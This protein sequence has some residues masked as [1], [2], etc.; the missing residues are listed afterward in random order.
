M[1]KVQMSINRELHLELEDAS[2]KSAKHAELLQKVED[3][4]ALNV[5]R[6]SAYMRWRLS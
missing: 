5:K 3:Y 2:Q 6:C 4:E 1:L